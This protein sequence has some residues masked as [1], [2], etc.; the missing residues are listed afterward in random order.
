MPTKKTIT[1]EIADILSELNK[2]KRSIN[3]KKPVEIARLDTIYRA[4]TMTILMMYYDK[5]VKPTFENTSEE[6]ALRR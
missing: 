3:H 6:S 1:A 2:G 5:G 4:L